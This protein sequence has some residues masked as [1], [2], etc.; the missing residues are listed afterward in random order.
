MS[1][2]TERYPAPAVEYPVARS[3]RLAGALLALHATSLAVLAAWLWQG[4]GAQRPAALPALLLWGAAA[5]LA[6]RFW[7]RQ[8]VGSLAWDGAA[9]TL[10]RHAGQ[11]ADQALGGAVVV[12][13]D[14]QRQMA[15]A[16]PLARPALWLYVEHSGHPARWLD[17][18][19][20]VYSRPNAARPA[21][22][23]H[24]HRERAP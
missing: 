21:P 10:S 3:K 19:R 22:E 15:L 7:L 14:L 9:W 5:A 18:R 8:P 4:A 13:L 17:L 1:A 11:A 2:G 16:F 20:A 24:R 23:S 6:A 12:Q